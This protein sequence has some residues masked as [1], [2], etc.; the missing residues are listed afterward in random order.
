M[1]AQ[2]IKAVRTASEV[3]TNTTYAIKALFAFN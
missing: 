2:T 3:D 1:V